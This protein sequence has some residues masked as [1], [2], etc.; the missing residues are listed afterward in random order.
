MQMPSA[1]LRL[2]QRGVL[3]QLLRPA[4]AHHQAH[5]VFSSS[6]DAFLAPPTPPRSCTC[7]G[8]PPPPAARR[9]QSRRPPAQGSER[10]MEC[11][12]R[13][14]A[15]QGCPACLHAHALLAA[16]APAPPRPSGRACRGARAVRG[17]AARP[18]SCT[19][20]PWHMSMA[21]CSRCR[22]RRAAA[23]RGAAAGEQRDEAHLAGPGPGSLSSCTLRLRGSLPWLRPLAS[24][25]CSG[26][27]SASCAAPDELHARR[28]TSGPCRA[29]TQPELV[30]ARDRISIVVVMSA[31]AFAACLGRT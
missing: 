20:H 26:A 5:S 1:H 9:W 18:R 4:S 17:R 19:Q 22:T 30:S 29:N 6:R 2:V 13:C 28:D 21:D 14:L 31:I 11:G 10:V 23:S 3:P 25:R 7:R 8:A 16:P 15:P 24:S 27:A 12:R